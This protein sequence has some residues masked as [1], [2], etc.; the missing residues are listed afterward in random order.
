M[1]LRRERGTKQQWIGAPQVVAGDYRDLHGHPFSSRRGQ[2]ARAAA[3]NGATPLGIKRNSPR[4]WRFVWRTNVS[5]I[6]NPWADGDFA[7]WTGRAVDMH[8]SALEPV[9]ATD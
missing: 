6:P 5:Y 9:Y 7:P 3:H 1:P 4:G 8:C 2:Q